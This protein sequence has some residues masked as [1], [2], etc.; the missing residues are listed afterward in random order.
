MEIEAKTNVNHPDHYQSNKG[1]ECIEAIEAA[2]EGVPA[3]EAFGVGTAIKYLWR[4]RKKGRPIE[5]LEKAKWYIDRVIRIIKQEEN[6][7]EY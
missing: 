4:Y 3:K 2:T 6:T 7:I 1:I 5:D